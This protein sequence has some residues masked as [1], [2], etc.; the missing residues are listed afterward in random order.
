MTPQRG[1]WEFDGRAWRQFDEQG[2]VI[3]VIESRVRR[4]EW[5]TYYDM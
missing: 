2:R 1:G 4:M 3:Q 5:T